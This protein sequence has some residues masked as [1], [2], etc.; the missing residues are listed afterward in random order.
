MGC[1]KYEVE[2]HENFMP[3]QTQDR[4]VC[5]FQTVSGIGSESGTVLFFACSMEDKIPETAVCL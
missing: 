5:V 1:V 2:S 3:E 4:S